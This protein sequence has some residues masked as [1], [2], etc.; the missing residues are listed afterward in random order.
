LCRAPKLDLIQVT[1]VVDRIVAAAGHAGHLVAFE[2]IE[3]GQVNGI[4][5]ERASAEVA[6]EAFAVV[7]RAIELDIFRAWRRTQVLDVDVPQPPKLGN[8]A[9]IQGLIRMAGVTRLLHWNSMVLEMRC[10][11]IRGI[12]HVQALP[13][14]FHD[15]AAETERRL[16]G[17]IDVFR[18]S[19]GHAYHRE[20]QECH[21]RQHF[22]FA[23]V[24]DGRAESDDGDENGA[25][26]KQNVEQRRG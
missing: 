6:E 21:E 4:A 11:Q 15:V 18:G 20:D 25:D 1:H 7:V 9:A 5:F 16:L 23:T 10:R 19:P 2:R 14:R 17:T 13:V 22:A 8:D 26:Y 12:V 3:N 24:R